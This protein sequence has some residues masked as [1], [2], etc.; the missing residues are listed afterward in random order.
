VTRV[1]LL[2]AGPLGL[3]TKRVGVP[4][5][6]ACRNWAAHC[7][8]QGVSVHVPAIAYYEVSREL[9]RSGKSAGMARLDSYC[10]AVA[11]RYLRLTDLAL[12]NA[13]R[14]WADAR[15]IGMPTAG[16]DALDADVILAAQALD[17]GLPKSDYVVAT[18]NVG[19]LARFVPAA[20]WTDIIP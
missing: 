17:L 12:R 2:D 3:V 16:R 7:I 8:S 1:I 10:G 14:L 4:E 20:L 15:S 6:D 9:V 5:A 11:D 13:A 19:H 18:T